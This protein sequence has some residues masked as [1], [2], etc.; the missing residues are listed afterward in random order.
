M[1]NF[2][3]RLKDIKAFVFDVDGVFSG[4]MVLDSNGRLTRTMSAKDGFAVKTA[5]S[6]GFLIGIIT[7]GNADF[8]RKRFSLLGV[9]DI[10]L[11]SHNKI[12]DYEDFCMKYDLQASQILYMGDDIPDYAPMQVSGLSACPADAAV[13][14]KNIAHYI[15]EKKGG[16]GC[17]RDVIEQVMRAHECWFP[18]NQKENAPD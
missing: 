5:I 16:N 13:E 3:E 8:V 11:A 10:Y 12:E 9:N 17:V 18:N 4:N 15:S 1:D 7:G 6:K 14:I 2:K